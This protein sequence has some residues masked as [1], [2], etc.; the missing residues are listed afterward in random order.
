MP[1]KTGSN[2]HIT[3]DE[4]EDFEDPPTLDPVSKDSNEVAQE[5]NAEDLDSD[6]APEEAAISAEKEDAQLRKD[7]VKSAVSRRR[8]EI[9]EKRKQQHE[10][11]K[12]QQEEKRKRL[13]ER[14]LPQSF[15]EAA[16]TEQK[17]KTF[18]QKQMLPTKKK[19]KI[20][21]F[22]DSDGEDNN[23]SVENVDEEG[24]IT[25]DTGVKVR[26][27]NQEVKKYTDITQRAADFRMN[28]LYRRNTKRVPS[29]Q[30]REMKIKQMKSGKAVFAT[31][32]T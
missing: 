3:F 22:N 31:H 15:L 23:G 10:K 25:I 1:L 26:T 17:T 27:L 19:N 24:F 8:Q 6:A 28:A 5:E 14:R 32:K 29:S 4:D 13:E 18:K 30:L 12:L 7:L 21:K 16:A 2:R 9:K 20:R 11:N